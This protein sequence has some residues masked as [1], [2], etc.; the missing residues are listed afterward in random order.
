MET[1]K[2]DKY[3]KIL[4][5]I[6]SEDSLF[7]YKLANDGSLTQEQ[8]LAVVEYLRHYLPKRCDPQDKRK[9]CIGLEIIDLVINH[10]YNTENRT[11][12]SELNTLSEPPRYKIVDPD[13]I[14]LQ[15]SRI[16][17]YGD[18]ARW[19]LATHLNLFENLNLEGVL[20]KEQSQA[21]DC[22][23]IGYYLGDSENCEL[24]FPESQYAA[25]GLDL[26]CAIKLGD[27]W[28]RG[29]WIPEIGHST[30]DRISNRLNQMK[31]LKRPKESLG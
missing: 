11:L 13:Y 30:T 7:G 12:M 19:R 31:L 17:K 28:R 15:I 10:I 4:W 23:A 9:V 22:F 20:T 14:D 1:Q 25:I 29:E 6:A 5:E 3:D 18:A 24:D 27:I 2:I 16:A 21:V 8:R 26:H